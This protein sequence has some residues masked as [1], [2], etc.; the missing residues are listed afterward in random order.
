MIRF[1]GCNPYL[2]RDYPNESRKKLLFEAFSW[3]VVGN[4]LLEY[5]YIYIYIYIYMKG[6]RSIETYNARPINPI[7]PYALGVEI[8]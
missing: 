4:H 3:E 5:I 6:V 1:V 8:I 2:L 7:L